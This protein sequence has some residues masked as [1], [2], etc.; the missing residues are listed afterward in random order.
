M[1]IAIDETGNFDENSPDRHFFVAAFIQSENGALERKVKQLISWENSLPD[2][3]R[4][5]N[6]EIKGSSLKEEHFQKFIPDVFL[7]DPE[8]RTSYVS[9]IPNENKPEVIQ[10][11][12]NIEVSQIQYSLEKFRKT[13]TRKANLNFLDQYWKWLNKRSI[14]EYLKM[15]CLKHC[16]KDTLYNNMVYCIVKDRIDEILN[17]QYKIDRDFLNDENIYW[18]D[19]LRKSIENESKRKPFPMLDTWDKDHPVRQKYLVEDHEGKKGFHLNSVFRD[20]LS[21]LESHENPEIRI[22]DIIGIILNRYWNRNE[23]RRE[24]N[25]LT[26]RH[27]A[28]DGHIQL[29][30]N[31]FEYGEELKKFIEDDMER[32]AQ[33][34][35]SG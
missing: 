8:I 28:K 19:Y 22:A 5:K 2:I 11:Y 32:E 17:I 12:L 10:K 18:N 16:L 6:G 4:N 20:N 24:H 15:M 34:R 7:E 9:I 14:R 25:V 21:F 23:L 13:G 29:K 27:A 1:I 33:R 3:L 26:K 31:D 30:F 35:T